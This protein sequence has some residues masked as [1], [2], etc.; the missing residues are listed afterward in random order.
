MAVS[1]LLPPL[2]ACAA[3]A[4]RGD[5]GGLGSG[6]GGGLGSGNGGGLGSGA[7]RRFGIGG[8]RRFEIA[9]APLECSGQ[10]G[11]ELLAALL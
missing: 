5:G 6:D 1:C 7:W 4:D 11:R 3:A 8:R 2:R 10:A 9:P